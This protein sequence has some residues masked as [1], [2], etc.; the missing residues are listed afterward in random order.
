MLPEVV[1]KLP[2]HGTFNLHASL[3]PEFRGAAPIHWSIIKG[4]T[5]TGVTTFFID[6]KIDTGHI[7]LQKETPIGPHETVGILHDRLM[8]MGSDLV[9]ETVSMIAH[10]DVSTTPQ[11]KIAPSLA[12]KLDKELTRIDWTLSAE[13]VYNKIRGLN[14]F[15]AAW[16][17]LENER[18]EEP[19]KIYDVRLSDESIKGDPGK[20]RIGSGVI[21]IFCGNG[22]LIIDSLQLPGRK[23]MDSKSLLNGYRFSEKAKMR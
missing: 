16:T 22:A 14:P 11:P 18:N 9:V 15:P 1:W 20:I 5:K 10:G 8:D 13:E 3:L 12:P 21:E 17:M 6:E 7:I 2:Q 19:V 23:R 4:A